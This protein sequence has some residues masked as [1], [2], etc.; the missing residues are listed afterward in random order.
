[1]GGLGGLLLHNIW[2]VIAIIGA[3]IGLIMYM[4]NRASW[5]FW[6]M[7]AWY[8]VPILGKLAQLGRD[9]SVRQVNNGFLHSEDTLGR[10]YAQ[11]IKFLTKHQFDQRMEYLRKSRDNGRKPLP[12]WL[13]AI[14]VLLVAAEGYGFS[15][16]L[17]PFFGTDVSEDARQLITVALVIVLCVCLVMVTHHAGHHLYINNLVT[18]CE[19]SWDEKGRPGDLDMANIRLGMD[20]SVD[21]RDS[22]GEVMPAYKQCISRVGKDKVW[23]WVISAF[24]I[25]IALGVFQV[26]VRMYAVNR[27]Q[28]ED[29]AALP[30]APSPVTSSGSDAVPDFLNQ[31][32]HTVDDKAKNE[33]KSAQTG[34][35]LLGSLTLLVIYLMTQGVGLFTGYAYGFGGKDSKAAYKETRGAAAYE[36][37]RQRTD[38]WIDI[39]EARLSALHQ[40]IQKRVSGTGIVLDRTFRDYLISARTAASVLDDAY[41]EADARSRN[42]KSQGDQVA[43]ALQAAR[44]LEPEK[45][46]EL[47]R[48]LPIEIRKSVQE[49]LRKEREAAALA[50]AANDTALDD[51]LDDLLGA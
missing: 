27:A 50:K 24:V 28:I 9:R 23:S 44:K 15:Y 49:A 6:L 7:N 11:H 3:A 25:I 39:A 46:K 19:R 2:Y 20:Q 12:G 47:I 4:S 26:G 14:L 32:Q 34:E 33:Q 21:D 48:G 43:N 51:E 30:P 18:S 16:L 36:D 29:S 1:M 10:D 5:D 22:N 45:A 37:Y 40:M 17:A 31:A 13:V 42:V 35:W 41:E 8:G 38:K